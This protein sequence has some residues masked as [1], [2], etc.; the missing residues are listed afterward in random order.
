MVVDKD[1]GK[2]MMFFAWGNCAC[3]FPITSRLASH[4]ANTWHELDEDSAKINKVILPLTMTLPLFDQLKEINNALFVRSKVWPS[5][6][7]IVVA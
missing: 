3:K 6:V 5:Y 1:C 4:K 2:K 7:Q